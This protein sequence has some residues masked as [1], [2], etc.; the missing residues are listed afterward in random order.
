MAEEGLPGVLDAHP[1][2]VRVRQPQH[3]DA[4]AVDLPV[5]QV[6]PLA[7]ELVDPVDVDGGERVALVDREVARAPVE[8]ARAREDDR[9][10]R[11]VVTARL[12]DRELRA[13]VDLEVGVRVGHRVEVARLAGE[14]EDHVAPAHERPQ[15]VLVPDVR[16]V[17]VH[18][19]VDPGDVVPAAAVL[20]DERVDEAD[21]RARRHERVRE[22]RA[23]EAEAAG[24]QHALAL[25]ARRQFGSDHAAGVPRED[26]GRHLAGDGHRRDDSPAVPGRDAFEIDQGHERGIGPLPPVAADHRDVR[27]LA[28]NALT[29]QHDVARVRAE[30]PV[31][32]VL[33]VR[34][35]VDEGARQH[36]VVAA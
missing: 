6:V 32:R 25:E 33:P 30:E 22:V 13:A 35:H 10:L 16:D 8:L 36:H 24:D 20:R 7:G 31:E 9:G 27:A 18:A 11:V 12:E 19:V 17:D 29:V 1:R 26:E 15:A 14:V 34:E 3:G 23:D 21:V 2:P 5:E 4:D 28:R